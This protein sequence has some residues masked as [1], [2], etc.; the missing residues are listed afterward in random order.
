MQMRGRLNI[1][2]RLD[3]V[4]KRFQELPLGHGPQTKQ[5]MQFNGQHVDQVSITTA[6]RI[7]NGTRLIIPIPDAI[8]CTIVCAPNGLAQRLA[9]HGYLAYRQIQRAIQLL[10]R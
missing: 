8:L 4:G 6:G 10:Y 5:V 7:I 2:A 3:S 1:M 9:C